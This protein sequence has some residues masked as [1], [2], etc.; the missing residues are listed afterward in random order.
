MNGKVVARI[1][2]GFVIWSK[3]AG[4][5]YYTATVKAQLIDTGPGDGYC[6]RM[7]IHLLGDPDSPTAKE[8]NGVWTTRTI[9]S[10]ESE[11]VVIQLYTNKNGA[12]PLSWKVNKPA[13]W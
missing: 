3:K 2:N 12:W 6:A 13:S 9:S 4:K 7:S 5:P 11:F 8:C 1:R 10:Y